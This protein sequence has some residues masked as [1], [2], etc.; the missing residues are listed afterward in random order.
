FRAALTGRLVLSTLHA[1]STVET[2]TRL[3]DMGLEP[4]AVSSG[5]SVIIAQ[6]LARRLCDACKKSAPADPDAIAWL[7]GCVATEVR[8]PL[9]EPK[10]CELCGGTGYRG[11]TA[12]F[13]VVT[14]D[15]EIRDSIRSKAPTRVYRQLLAKRQV[16]TLRR[17]GWLRVR[18]GETTVDEVMRV[19]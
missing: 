17:E 7:L 9:F 4:F 16:P 14:M 2:I 19:C 13:E 6:R 11:R 10:G 15:D 8:A 12:I 1:P 3:L 18:A 5:L